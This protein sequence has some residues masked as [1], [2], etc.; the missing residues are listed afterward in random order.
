ME[1]RVNCF[2]IFHIFAVT[3][4]LLPPCPFKQ[5]TFL[6]VTPYM[7]GLGLWQT[8]SVFA[9]DPKTWTAYLTARVTLQN[10]EQREW[11]FPRLEKLDYVT[12]VFKD[13][14]RKWANDCVNDTKNSKVW[15][16]TCKYIARQ[17]TDKDNPPVSVSLI[18]HW[19][20]MNLPELK[21]IEG[22]LP[23]RY[24]GKDGE[25]ILY[26]YKIMRRVKHSE[27]QSTLF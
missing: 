23:R 5:A 19:Q 9:P 14:Y 3:T 25:S 11:E 15:P 18:R 8:W 17:F 27:S 7:A 24:H 6:L 10:G 20:Y 1:S 2:I 21:P 4:W 22:D 13:K 26:T 16:D 12:R